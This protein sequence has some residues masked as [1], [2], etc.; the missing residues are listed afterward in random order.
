MKDGVL[1]A[2]A[3]IQTGSCTWTKGVIGLTDQGLERKIDN[4]YKH[5]VLAYKEHHIL[6]PCLILSA[7]DYDEGI[8]EAGCGQTRVRRF[9]LGVLEKRTW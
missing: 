4:G 9:G 6:Q 8:D 3:F 1:L 5:A 2:D 7:R